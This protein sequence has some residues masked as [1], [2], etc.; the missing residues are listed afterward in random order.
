MEKFNLDLNAKQESLNRLRRHYDKLKE[1]LKKMLIYCLREMDKYRDILE[2]PLENVN[3][4][5]FIW[6]VKSADDLTEYAEANL[7]TMNDFDITYDRKARKYLLGIETA[8]VFENKQAEVKYLVKLLR[9]FTDYMIQHSYDLN[10][11][12]DLWM[13][14]PEL[15]FKAESIPELYTQFKIFVAGYSALYGN[16]VQNGLND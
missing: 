8:Y 7:Y 6:G 14:Q 5:K 10:E 11:E 3:S 12:Y 15:N 13:V 2:H 9:L 1:K 4:I 16:E